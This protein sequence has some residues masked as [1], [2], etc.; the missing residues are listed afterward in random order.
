MNKLTTRLMAII[1]SFATG[2]LIV[3][4]WVYFQKS[5]P[6]EVVLPKSGWARIFFNLID[7]VT[8]KAAIS[9][10]RKE[11]LPAD[12]IEIR[13]WRGFGL[14][15]LEGIVLKRTDNRWSA[16]H[17][18]ADNYNLPVE[19]VEV[20]P[21][22][23][24]N[25]GWESFWKQ[26]N[27]KRLL[28]LPDPSE[29]NCEVSMIDGTGHVVEINR[30]RVYRTFRYHTAN[31]KCAEARQMSEIG[32]LIGVEFDTGREQCKTTEWFACAALHKRVSTNSNQPRFINLGGSNFKS[33]GSEPVFP[34]DCLG[35]GELGDINVY[36][37]S[38]SSEMA[39]YTFRANCRGKFK[40]VET[41]IQLNE[42]GEKIG[43]RCVVVFSA[44][45]VRIVWTES[46]KDVWIMSAPTLDLVREFEKSEVYKLYKSRVDNY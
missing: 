25:S 15:N 46:E 29:I 8:E 22:G 38:E 43:E 7:R 31:N 39:R 14:S 19:N 35:C 17:L 42:K 10:L 32:E 20:I 34:D 44:D 2:V 21:L 11:S 3:A 40:V 30:N 6:V 45:H 16:T 1:L 27:D 9:E 33:S 18:K 41:G 26:I 24:P 13:I 5:P 36:H 37:N 23:E 12:D 4:G 28:D